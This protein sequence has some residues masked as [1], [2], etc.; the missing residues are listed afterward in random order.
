[1]AP[2][3]FPVNVRF[4]LTNRPENVRLVRELLAGVGS[5]VQLSEITLDDAMIAVSE[6][7]NNAVL[8]AYGGEE[9]PLEVEFGVA[10]DR[11]EVRCRD[12]GFGIA[13]DIRPVPGAAEGF[14]LSA[15]R[16]FTDAAEI[17]TPA[18]AGTMV[19]MTFSAPGML[20]LAA[21]EDELLDA[22]LELELDPRTG[23]SVAIAPA[24]LA[25]PILTRLATAVGARAGFTIDRLSDIQLMIDALTA[26]GAPYLTP[27]GVVATL[28]S[29]TRR[30]ELRIGPISPRGLEAL[31]GGPSYSS[32]AL[33]M[34]T[35][36]DHFELLPC[37]HLQML[38]L[39][40]TER[41]P[42]AG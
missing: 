42:S 21:A 19:R 18:G 38:S 30:V 11:F 40:L 16:A 15:I 3:A 37:L 6:A 5:A 26:S 23:T 31:S 41:R 17:S 2:A 28:V 14:G 27:A 22:A 32:L 9:G 29:D 39:V 24:V 4:A 7:S 34:A 8:H 13:P 10:D 35:L 1:M 36:T 25:N 12:Y 33:I 20:G